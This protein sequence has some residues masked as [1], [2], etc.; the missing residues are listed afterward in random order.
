MTE[1]QTPKRTYLYGPAGNRAF[2][3][4]GP[5]NQVLV[6]LEVWNETFVSW[7]TVRQEIFPL[8]AAIELYRQHRVYGWRGGEIGSLVDPQFN[9][10]PQEEENGYN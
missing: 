7:Q 1:S 10:T 6:V 2:M 8:E 4:Q 9:P 3:V 5:T